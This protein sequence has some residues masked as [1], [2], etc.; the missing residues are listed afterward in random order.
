MGENKDP[1]YK[2]ALTSIKDFDRYQEFAT[3]DIQRGIKYFLKLIL[4]FSIVLAIAITVKVGMSV[5]H[6]ITALKDENL[7]ITF[8]NN[9]LSVNNGD[10]I[11][12]DNEKDFPGIII[13]DTSETDENKWEEYNKKIGLYENG[14]LILKDK[15]LL[16][17][18]MIDTQISQTY[19]EIAKQYNIGDFTKDE[20]IE[21]ITKQQWTIYLSLWITLCISFFII[22]MTYSLLDCIIPILM[23]Y[24][25]ARIMGL[26]LKLGS[27]FNITVHA[28]TLPI[29]LNV[30]YMIVNLFTGFYI[31]YFYIMYTA[32]LY[33]YLVTAIILIRSNLIKQQM[34]LMKI[35]EEQK[36]VKEEI[37]KQD[38]KEEQDKEKEGPSTEEKEEKD[39]EEKKDNNIGKEAKGEV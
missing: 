3:E 30:V 22:Y 37:R 36:N 25:I 24:F 19:E 35:I 28:L 39:K 20:V 32:I 1:F 6:G 9:Q 4:I 27:L 31:E 38:E 11:I 14:I 5:N 33:I 23:G 2:V 8:Q 15:I 21:K 18:S 12:I 17:N 26:K 13:I 16:K 34:E 10:S 7:T 29:L